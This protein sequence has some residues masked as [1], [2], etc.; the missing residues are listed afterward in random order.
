VLDYF[1]ARSKMKFST[2]RIRET[3]GVKFELLLSRIN[4]AQCDVFLPLFRFPKP[5]LNETRRGWSGLR[6]IK[7]DVNETARGKKKNA[8]RLIPKIA[9]RG[10]FKETLK[11]ARRKK[12]R[13]LKR[14][15]REGNSLIA[16]PGEGCSAQ[17]YAKRCASVYSRRTTFHKKPRLEMIFGKKPAA[18]YLAKLPCAMIFFRPVQKIPLQKPDNTVENVVE[19]HDA[20]G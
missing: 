8:A 19:G 16:R 2:R 3:S 6:R 12:S 11:V 4:I 15:F 14:Q 18:K 5:N 7:S 10:C 17:K 1:F 9:K 20:R 13:R